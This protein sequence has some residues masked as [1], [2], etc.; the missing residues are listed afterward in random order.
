M[1]RFFPRMGLSILALAA[2]LMALWYVEGGRA[3]LAKAEVLA[4]VGIGF[5]ILGHDGAP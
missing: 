3:D 5:A 1:K 2:L 4:L